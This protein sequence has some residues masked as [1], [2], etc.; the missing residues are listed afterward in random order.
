M[1]FVVSDV[2]SEEEISEVV[3]GEESG[4]ELEKESSELG[5]EGAVE[6]LEEE[7]MIC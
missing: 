4:G 6:S 3:S 1:G 2:E 7:L 5:D